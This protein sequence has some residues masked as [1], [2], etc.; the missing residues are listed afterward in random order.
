M[1]ALSIRRDRTPIVLRKLAKAE[2]DARVARRMLAIANALDGMSR[3][4]AARSAGMDRQT[5]RD[6][7]IRYNAHG[8]DGLADHWG[9]GRPPKLSAQAK[10]EL[11]AIV[12]AGPDPEASGISTF[13]REDLVR[14]CKERFGK[15]LHVSSMGRILH[16][17]GL[18]RQKARPSHPQKDPAAQAAFKKTSVSASFS[19]TR[20]ASARREG[21]ATSGGGAVSARQ[22]CATSAL[23]SPTSSRRSNPALTTASPS[24]CRTPTPRQ[25]RSSS[26]ASLPRSGRTSMSS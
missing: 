2:A 14:I 3:E 12:L 22:G 23:R 4:E 25:C 21:R 10:A 16:E 11:V 18:S 20:R 1:I 9:D 7:V 8:I 24:L 13:T 6:W 5:L 19:R 15:G 17:L 26:T